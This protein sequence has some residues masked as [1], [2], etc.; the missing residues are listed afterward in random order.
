[1]HTQ[2][3]LSGGRWVFDLES[4]GLLD[5]I[6]T[7]WCIVC[8]NIDTGEVREYG[9]SD[10]KHAL[11]LLA[12]ADEIIG[13]N[14]LDYDIPAIQIVHPGWT[15]K[16]KATDT[17]VLSRLIYGDL[18]NDDA[19][20]NFSHDRFP[21]KLWGSHSLKA[22]GMRI[23]DFKDDYD[24]GWEA[25]S[26]VMLSYCVQDTKVTDT[27]YKKLMTTEPSQ[28]SIDLEHRMASI[29]KEIGSNG[30]TFDKSKATQLYALLAQKRHEIEDSLKDLFE[31]WTV[32]ED[33]YP[34][35]DN[36]TL[37][38]KAGE[39]FVKSK[40][41]YFNPGSRQHI[42]KCLKD[43]YKWKPKEYTP[44]GQ[45]KIDETIL[46]KLKYPEAK[47]LAE[48][49]L[50][51]KRIG[52]LAEGNGAWLKKVSPDG[53]LRHR[54]NSN[55]CVSSRAS[56]SGPNLQQVPSAGSLYGK[57]CRELF[58][59]PDG[60]WLCGTD[61]SGIELRLLASY[62]EPYD[63]GE[64][65]KQILEGDIHTFNQHATGL[66]T[67]NLAKTWV[68][69]TLY[70]GG[71]SL[72]GAIA[73]GGAK[74]GKELKDNYDK[75]VPAFATLKKNLKTAFGRGYIK[76]LDG[77]KLKVRSE[78]RCLSQ[79]L[80]SAG[81]I[82]A[83]QWV[84][85]TYDQI[86]HKYGEDTVIVGWIHDEIQVACRTKEIAEDVGSIAGRMAEASGIALSVK[87]PIGSEYTVGR[88]WAETH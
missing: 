41:V 66:A 31:P 61:L 27:L 3:K 22:W 86:K 24:G 10:I 57:E 23:G 63:G 53:K 11:E 55:G 13:H 25:F 18:F 1:M 47:K 16:G 32:E 6:H 77:R 67:R 52:M 72:I 62:L 26:D 39:L 54:L 36:K 14:I 75:A 20:R 82:V 60:W 64:Y 49:F 81:A 79:L 48:F 84:M 50:L 17:L 2:Q 15:Y 59:V 73:G 34:K 70:G 29:C 30:W 21:K 74:K 76:A 88:T 65:A 42:E 78:H 19:E 58:G 12:N 8:R 37:G 56:S 35:R 4:N 87:I 68:Y 80:Q 28:Q 38:Y 43:K 45:A 46:S 5:T 7:I 51:Q 40:T 85:M 33:F 44:N 9:P 71:D 83:K 69:A